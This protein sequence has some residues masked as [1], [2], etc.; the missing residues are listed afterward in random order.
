MRLDVCRRVQMESPAFACEK[1]G[2]FRRR[3]TDRCACAGAAAYSVGVV[4]RKRRLDT[5]CR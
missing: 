2:F 3:I 1:L 5:D 4:G